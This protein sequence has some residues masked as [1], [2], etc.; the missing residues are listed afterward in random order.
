MA[1]IASYLRSMV[2]AGSSIAD[3]PA[4]SPTTTTGT[5]GWPKY[6][7]R[8][9]STLRMANIQISAS[10]FLCSPLAELNECYSTFSSQ[11]IKVTLL[12]VPVLR[13]EQAKSI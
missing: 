7:R 11:N 8:P 5:S 12:I 13:S 3:N 4:T 1:T 10:L 9:L 2:L 6:G